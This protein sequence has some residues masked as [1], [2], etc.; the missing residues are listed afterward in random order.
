MASNN[1][2]FHVNGYD[3]LKNTIKQCGKEKRIFV[4]F[5]AS[6]DSQGHSWYGKNSLYLLNCI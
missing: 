3:E 5:Y 6:K 1:K 4:L 2:K